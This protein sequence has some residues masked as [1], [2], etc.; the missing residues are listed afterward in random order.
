M[1]IITLASHSYV[2]KGGRK[3]PINWIDPSGNGDH[4]RSDITPREQANRSLASQLEGLFDDNALSESIRRI[5]EA[6]ATGPDRSDAESRIIGNVTESAR[7]QRER[8]VKDFNEKERQKKDEELEELLAQAK[9]K[10]LDNS[11]QSLE[12]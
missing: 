2:Y 3:V 9:K 7:E 4:R 6:S 5:E 11:I 1:A 8:I 12:I 10:H